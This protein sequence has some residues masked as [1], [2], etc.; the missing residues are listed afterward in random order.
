MKTNGE[1]FED[2]GG[3]ECDLDGGEIFVF[4]YPSDTV[5]IRLR[6]MSVKAMVGLRDDDTT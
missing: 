6:T 5:F 3:C 1:L 2:G 4:V